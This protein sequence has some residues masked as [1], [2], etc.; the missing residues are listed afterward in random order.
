[1]DQPPI[2]QESQPGPA[3][4]PDGGLPGPA[5]VPQ[6]G[7][8]TP[9]APAAGASARPGWLALVSRFGVLIALVLLVVVF[10]ALRPHVFFTTS[11]VQSIITLAAPTLVVALGLSI[12][13]TMNDFDLS[14]GG[15]IGLGGSAAV[16]LM[17]NEHIAWPVAILGGLALGV[18]FGLLNGLIVTISGASSFI[19]TLGMTSVMTGVEFLLTGEQTIYSGIS[20]AYIKIGQGAFL[21]INY[22]VWIAI[23]LTVATYLFLHRTETGRYMFAIGNS[24]GAARLAGIRMRQLRTAGFAI[25]AFTAAVAGILITAQGASST[26]QAGTPYLLPSYAA[27]FLGSAVFWP[28][29][30][31]VPGTVVGVLFL[32]VIQTGLSMLGLSTAMVNIVEGAVLVIAITLSRLD[33]R[34]AGS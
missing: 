26:P 8:P 34:M 19:V 24:P 17:A 23:V 31:N 29:R 9:A 20:P 15:M 6:A 27:V 30:F 10:G 22:Q 3:G 33:R 12:V 32:G 13:L 25:A 4:Q 14:V 21:G 1:M 5:G 18:G 7:S 2:A 16:V 28:G 11:N